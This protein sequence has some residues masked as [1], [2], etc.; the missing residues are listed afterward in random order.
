[1]QIR[2]VSCGAGMAMSA[3]GDRA[4]D[5]RCRYKVRWNSTGLK[6]VVYN[7]I[8]EPSTSYTKQNVPRARTRQ[9]ICGREKPAH[10]FPPHLPMDSADTRHDGL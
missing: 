3:Q 8:E 1:M 4:G 7:V 6:V 9:L 10:G 2:K 5:Y